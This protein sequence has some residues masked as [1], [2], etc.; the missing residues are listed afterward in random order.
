MTLMAQTKL[1]S[2][3]GSKAIPR[4]RIGKFQ[5]GVLLHS[6][7]TWFYFGLLRGRGMEGSMVGISGIDGSILL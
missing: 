2:H 1:I 3:L 6:I 5:V 7:V 4:T